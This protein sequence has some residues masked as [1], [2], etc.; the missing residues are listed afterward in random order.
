MN[1]AF[2]LTS[3][4]SLQ[5]W[6]E[7][8]WLDGGTALKSYNAWAAR[9]DKIYLITYGDK[10]D[11]LLKHHLKENFIILPKK[12]CLPSWLYSFIIPFVYK[13]ELRDSHIYITTQ[14]EGSWSAA[15][16]KLLYK[17][18]LIVRCG[19][20][21]SLSLFKKN[22]KGKLAKCLSPLLEKN[23]FRTAD[24]TIV[25][26]DYAK[27]YVIEK[28]TISEDKVT[29]IPNPVD[30][31]LFCPKTT[32]TTLNTLVYVGRLEKEKN[33]ELL[34]RAIVGLNV[35]LIIFGVGSLKSEINE[36]ANNHRIDVDFKNNVSTNDLAN[37]LKNHTIF[38]SPSKYEN[39]PKALLEAM[40]CGLAVIGTDVRGTNEVITNNYNGILCKPE[41]R[42]L[43][44]AIITLLNDVNLQKKLGQN[45]R[46]YI[47]EK[48]DLQTKI[49]ADLDVFRKVL[50]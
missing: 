38:I 26:S 29:V 34:M 49:A 50:S 20:L 4:T 40:S 48:F 33:P 14:M 15:L 22:F 42:D 11:L 46:T 39:S 35:K 27:Q 28:Y 30:T 17:K 24:H 13:N 23:I 12:V 41:S 8:G 1:L 43:R 6:K 2:F 31:S 19:Y 5:L 37:E 21:W 16:A 7:R 3:G 10:R 44:K 36:F 45:A 18:K 32:P 9:F 25:T 47:C